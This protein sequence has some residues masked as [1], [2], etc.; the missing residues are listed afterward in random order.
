MPMVVFAITARTKL[1]QRL[2]RQLALQSDVLES[3]MKEV[4][5]VL[6]QVF[7]DAQVAIMQDLYAG[8]RIRDDEHILLVEV[9]NS[10]GSIDSVWSSSL[11]TIS[12]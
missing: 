5:Q 3:K 8:F 7:P 10:G 12:W 4:E 2:A 1:E 6:Q 9:A 11:R